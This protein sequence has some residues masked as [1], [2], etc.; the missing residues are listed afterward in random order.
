MYNQQVIDR[1]LQ[2]ASD[3]LSSYDISKIISEEIG[4]PITSQTIRNFIKTS[5]LQELD[6]S[7]TEKKLYEISEWYYIFYKTQ[8]DIDW[9][10]KAIPYPIK[11]EDVDN[12][13]KDFSKHWGNLTGEQIIQKYSLKPETRNLLKSRL[14]LYKDS[15]IVSPYTLENV[16]NVEEYL[17][18]KINETIQ[19][20]YKN[21]FVKKDRE[22]KKRE[23]TRY[24]NFYHSQQ[25][26]L[27]N[28]SKVLKSY[29]PKAIGKFIMPK[30]E[31]NNTID[32]AFSD[33]HIGKQWT[34]EII[35]R[36]QTM[37]DYIISRNE[38]NIN[39]ICLWDLAESLVEGGMHS[40]QVDSMEWPFGFD[41]MMYIVE[42]FENMLISLY[43]AGKV[44]RFI[45]IAWNHDRLAKDHHQDQARTGALIIYEL[46]KRGVSGL[47]ISVEYYREKTTTLYLENF[48][49]IMN[50]WDESFDKKAQ[51]NAEMILWNNVDKN[52]KYNL[53]A[54]WDKHN[55]K[56]NE[57]KWY[58]A[59]G[60]PA[61]AGKWTY[62]TRLDLHSETWFIVME[63]NSKGTVDLL[64]KRL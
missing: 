23:F 9:S 34:Q 35:K 16:D 29:K 44:V 38:K 14:R 17:E 20:K 54:Y 10:R 19:D 55:I 3:W 21:I 18:W 56:M 50:H 6:N 25:D 46:I 32:V 42:I 2:L 7:M 53:I 12:I 60:L 47:N 57:W 49:L 59:I 15:N 41:L 37:T 43:K 13:F 24:S 28:V 30:L 51:S 11:V 64:I 22:I 40:W 62:D 4:K 39:L 33:I 27:D 5:G 45:G 61:L 36:L 48:N 58:T 8:T 63:K 52:W 1:A 31:N 26:F